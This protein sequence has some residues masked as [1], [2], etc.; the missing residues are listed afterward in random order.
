MLL[1]S[2]HALCAFRPLVTKPQ[3]PSGLPVNVCVQALHP[4][5]TLSQQT[6]SA[7]MPEA[8]ALPT[9]HGDPRVNSDGAS[10]GASRT[11]GAASGPPLLP[12]TP[13][14]SIPGVLGAASGSS[15]DPGESTASGPGTAPP[16]PSVPVGARPSSPPSAESV[17]PWPSTTT[18]PSRPPSPGSTQRQSSVQMYPGLHG[19]FDAQTSQ[20]RFKQASPKVTGR[21]KRQYH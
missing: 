19:A 18:S 13:A 12:P 20:S 2:V 3:V 5:Q 7:Q 10:E 15:T 17:S 11:S 4:V 8:Q 9:E 1:W 14:A 21:E 16:G 6:A